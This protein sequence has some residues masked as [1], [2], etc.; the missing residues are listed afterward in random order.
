MTYISL[1]HKHKD[2]G[3]TFSECNKYLKVRFLKGVKS[4]NIDTISFLVSQKQ[5]TIIN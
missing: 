3:M 1:F 5:G 4:V 2:V